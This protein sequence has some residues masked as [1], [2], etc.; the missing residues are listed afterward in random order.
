VALARKLGVEAS[1]RNIVTVREGAVQQVPKP[2]VKELR[3]RLGDRVRW[4]VRGKRLVG[5]KA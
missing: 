5:K 1:P 3:L 4:A 2:L